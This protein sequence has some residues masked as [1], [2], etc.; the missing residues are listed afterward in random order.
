MQ[1]F[2]DIAPRLRPIALTLCLLSASA[3]A[4][5]QEQQAGFAKIGGF[6]G[7]TVM[8]GF[9]FNGDTFDGETVYKEVDG[10]ELVFLPRLNKRPLIRG[11]LGYRAREVALEISYERTQ[12]EG[13]FVDFPLDSTFQAVNVDAKY[14]FAPNGRFQPHV[15]AGAAFPWF[16][17]KEGSFLDPDVGD[18]RFRGYGLNTEAGVTMFPTP[19]LGIGVGYAWRVMWFDR[20]TGVSDTLFELRP[21]FRETSGSLVVTGTFTF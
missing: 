4:W 1:T 12:H 19:Q 10:E 13:T 3:P 11:I 8:P 17:V 2:L 16:T 6:A 5:A 20:V 9:T 15:V 14:F 18:A 21:R 7:V